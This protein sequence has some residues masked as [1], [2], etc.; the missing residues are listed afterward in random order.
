MTGVRRP[1]GLSK[2][3]IT[4]FEQCPKKLWLS[5]HRRDLVERDPTILARMEA[6]NEAGAVACSL[7]P[8]GVMVIAQPD[9]QAA[10]RQT[11]DLLAGGHDRPIFEATFAHKNVLVQVDILEP[12]GCGDWIVAEVKSSTSVKDYHIGD[13]ATQ[14]W[15]MR[16][17]GLSISSAAIRHINTSF[18]LAQHGDYAGLFV[19]APL[20]SFL[21]PII[22]ARP[23][24]VEGAQN[25]L[26]GPEPETDMGDHCS[27]PLACEFQSYCSRNLPLPPEWPISLLPREGKKIAAQW[28]DAGVF[29]LRDLP[30]DALVKP[31]QRMIR[32]ATISGETFLDR[33]LINSMIGDWA[34]PRHYLDFETIAFAVPRWVGTRPY[35]QIPFQ[36]SCHSE[37]ADG[38]ISHEAFLSIDGADPRRACAED[39]INC[40]STAAAKKGAIIAYNASFERGCILKLAEAFP[41]L[42]GELEA[43][44]S[45][46]VD[47]L[48]VTRKGYYHRDQRGSWS[49]KAVLPTVA[50][51]L[52]Y[53]DLTVGNGE[54]AQRAWREA[55]DPA[56]PSE[57]RAEIRQ[58]LLDYCERDTWAMVVLLRRLLA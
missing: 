57:R 47:L 2:S 38:S 44:A 21:A 43:I 35:Q 12:T 33:K 50:A 11:H 17:A 37:R 23:T 42:A 49:I 3:R 58:A 51:E 26:A 20:D 54:D 5:V 25:A 52:D 19:D 14:V 13:L 7:L 53:G 36:F 22:A 46:V 29:D 24:V 6:G 1:A 40:L 39:L 34:W 4:A 45:R 55:V 56:T 10:L 16:E 28:A 15:V 18:V 31:Q 32:A 27:S 48:P 8:D 30:D 9:L 41:D